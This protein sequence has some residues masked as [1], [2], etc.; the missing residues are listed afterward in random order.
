LPSR[1]LLLLPAAAGNRSVVSHFQELLLR[2]LLLED[3]PADLVELSAD[4]LLPLLLAEPAAFGP[5][6]AHIAASAGAAGE[7]R[8]ATAVANALSQ[9]GGWL[10]G[11]ADQL[12]AGPA[13][14]GDAGYASMRSASRQFRQQL[15][16]MVADVR[17]LIRL[18]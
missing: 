11:H 10:Q 12:A 5:L 3:T 15:F 16:K 2:R 1:A 6:S 13:G 18:R 9:L 17:G 14:E 7:P 8:A 4:A